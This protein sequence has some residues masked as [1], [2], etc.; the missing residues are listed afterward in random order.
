MLSLKLQYFGHLMWTANSLEKT[1]MPGKIE[2]RRKGH[3]RMRWL[4]GITNA[5]DINLGKLQEM[6]KDREAWCAAV[7]G[8][9]ESDTTGWLNNNNIVS[10]YLEQNFCFNILLHTR[11]NNVC[12]LQK[13]WRDQW[14]KRHR[15]EPLV[16]SVTFYSFLRRNWKKYDKILSICLILTVGMWM[17]IT[18]SSSCTLGL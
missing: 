14:K 13:F 5:M 15:F 9:A 4:D 12:H 17:F 2:G 16:A 11:K 6:V 10:W 8:V 7:H 3:W 18:L 1:L